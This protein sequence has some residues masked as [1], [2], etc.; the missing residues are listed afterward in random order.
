MTI[1]EDDNEEVDE[2]E[3]EEAEEEDMKEEITS[4][5]LSEAVPP[6]FHVVQG[7]LQA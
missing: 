3:G 7:P 6:W 2:E 4:R 5:T 1:N